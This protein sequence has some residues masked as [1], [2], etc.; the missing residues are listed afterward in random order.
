LNLYRFSPS[1]C[2]SI[3]STRERIRSRSSRSARISPL[4]L[5]ASAT[6]R[7]RRLELARQPRVLFACPGVLAAKAVHHTDEQL[8]LLFQ[9]IDGLE[10]DRACCHCRFSHRNASNETGYPAPGCAAP[11]ITEI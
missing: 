5:S 7:A 2:C 6:A 11:V 1:I 4:A 10:I 8:D 9:A 3:S